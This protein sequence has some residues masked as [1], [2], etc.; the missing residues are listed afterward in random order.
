[1]NVGLSGSVEYFNYNLVNF[2]AL[3]AGTTADFLK[4]TKNKELKGSLW[5]QAAYVGAKAY[6]PL[7]SADDTFGFLS[8]RFGYSA[9]R[10]NDL[11]G[12]ATGGIYWS[13]GIGIDIDYFVLEAVYAKHNF[14][15]TF[16]DGTYLNLEDYS[17]VTL[18]VGIKSWWDFRDWAKKR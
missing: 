4:E 10:G 2:V 9:P 16:I 14:V 1:M 13:L 7:F 6:M 3:G 5:S 15:I 11:F 8:G 17:T 18:Y 12:S